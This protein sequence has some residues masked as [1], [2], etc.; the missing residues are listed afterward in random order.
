MKK[1]FVATLILFGITSSALAAIDIA[2]TVVEPKGDFIL[3]PA[4]ME[5]ALEPGETAERTIYITSRVP[6]ET[7][8]G[9]EIEDF[10]GSKNPDTPLVLLGKDSLEKSPYSFRD[11]VIVPGTNFSLKLGEKAAI[12]IKIQ[13]PKDAAPGGYYASVIITN[14]PE[15]DKVLGGGTRTVSR[16]GSLLFVRVKGQVKEEGRL[17]DFRIS[18]PSNRWL[19]SKAPTAF[20]LLFSN[21]GSVH[22]APRGTITITNIFGRKIEGVKIDPFFTLP[23]SLRSREILWSGNVV[24]GRYKATVDLERGYDNLSDT[25]SVVFW[26]IPWKFIVVAFLSIFILVFLFRYTLRNFEIKRK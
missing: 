8:F 21:D 3:D 14:K 12:P 17:E 11:N 9:I 5:F 2:Q 24:I 26:V 22:L 7:I 6:E 19:F 4:K 20:E 23:N 18:G 25:K 13:V 15:K 16:V 1:Y 10:V